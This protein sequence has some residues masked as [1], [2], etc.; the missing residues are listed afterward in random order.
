MTC[1]P[2]DTLAQLDVSRETIARLE[3]FASVLQK[4][5]PRI[6]LVSRNSLNE[7]WTRHIMDSIHVYRFAPVAQ[8]WADLGSGGGFPGLIVAI[9]AADESPTTHVTLIESDQR[10]AVFL[11]TAARETGVQCSVISQRIESAEPQNADV[12][13]ARALAELSVLLGFAE[14]HLKPNGT[15]LFPKGATWQKELDAARQQWHFDL[16]AIKSPTNPDAAILRIK[17]ISRV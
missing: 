15:A 3:V 12:L 17:G 14:R 10:K 5:N 7:L 8:H 1:F 6:N 11:R 9:L 2:V 16:E 4:W 13:S